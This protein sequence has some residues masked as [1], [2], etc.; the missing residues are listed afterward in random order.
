MSLI[1]RNAAVAASLNI[2]SLV[3]NARGASGER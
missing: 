3:L 2:L 1:V